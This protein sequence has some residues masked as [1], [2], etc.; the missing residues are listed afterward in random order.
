MRE[1]PKN[2]LSRQAGYWTRLLALLAAVCAAGPDPTLAAEL[3]YK[4]VL[5]AGDGS[6]PVFD[7]ATRAMRE[8]L[9]GDQVAPSDIRLLSADLNVVARGGGNVAKLGR[10][11]GAIAGLSAGPDHGC[12]VYATSHGT[13]ERGLALSASRS[14]LTPAA[15]D[16][17]L[18]RGCGNAP[19]VVI[20]SGCY[21]GDFASAPMARPNRII[22]TAAS[23][24]RPSFGCGAGR[25]FTV[26]DACLL[27]AM[28]GAV[29]W[30]EVY[31]Q[32]IACVTRQ[33]LAMDAP[34]SFPQAYFGA[35]VADLPVPGTK[36]DTTN[37]P[38]R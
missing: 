14:Y 1:Q 9:A 4:A 13:F 32:T 5:V 37:R 21:T 15:L 12:F 30:P 27:Q 28:D 8:R 10:V 11:V 22:L 18:S 23:D 33:E 3:R 20:V 36:Q 19:T 24:D 6:L 25:E 35:D 17:A 16:G 2:C 31:S 29:L 34:P 26:Y 7:N 38:A